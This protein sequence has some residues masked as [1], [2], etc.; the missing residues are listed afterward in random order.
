MVGVKVAPAYRIV[1][2]FELTSP[3]RVSFHTSGMVSD[4]AIRTPVNDAQEE[5]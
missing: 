1:A 5:V 2:G 3:A 4:L